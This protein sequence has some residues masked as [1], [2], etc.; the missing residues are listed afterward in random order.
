MSFESALTGTFLKIHQAVYLA[1]NGRFG[2]RMIGVPSLLLVTTGRRSGQ[3]RTAALVYAR[4]G[5]DLVLVA[6]NDGQ[7]RPPAWLLNAQANPAVE[8]QIARR[9]SD[10]VA[11]VVGPADADYTRLWM[12]VNDNNH[13]RYEGYQSRT[14]RPIMLLVVTPSGPLT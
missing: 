9:R 5:S 7:D 2:H 11:R 12:L 6:S 1:S 3:R 10:A 8:V 14:D 13:H 4:D